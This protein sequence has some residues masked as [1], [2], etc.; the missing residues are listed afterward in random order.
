MPGTGTLLLR[1]A[2][3]APST[4]ARSALRLLGVLLVVLGIV[5]MHQMAGGTHT[6]AMQ[7]GKS[8]GMS[9]SAMTA[10]LAGAS[11]DR[12]HPDLTSRA[13][14]VVGLPGV[15]DSAHPAAHLAVHQPPGRV[16]LS[17][18][19]AARGAGAMPLCL[20]VLAGLLL[21]GL[22]M[23][24]ARRAPGTRYGGPRVAA[25]RTRPPGR[26]PPRDLLA[27]LCVLRT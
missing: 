23:L 10:P 18:A 4:S 1:P 26:G 11:L 17:A 19:A 16:L 27:Q 14:A 9:G 22:P 5:A 2:R 20:A 7:S 13:T 25:S 24:L 15:S 3:P 12:I 21:I 8:A 6:G